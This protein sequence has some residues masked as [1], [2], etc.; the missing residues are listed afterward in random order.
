MPGP[1]LVE[2]I[3]PPSSYP[4]WQLEFALGI[5]LTLDRG[6]FVLLEPPHDPMDTEREDDR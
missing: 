2:T 6:R 4:A 3:R 5:C 1:Y